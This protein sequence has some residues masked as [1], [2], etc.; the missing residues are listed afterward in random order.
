MSRDEDLVVATEAGPV[1]G[2]VRDLEDGHRSI[3]FLGVPYAAAPVGELR[4]AAPQPVSPWTGV[5]AAVE[6]GATPLR[7]QVDATLIPE[8]AVPGEETLNVNVFTPDITGFAPVMVWI[9]GGGFVSGSPNSPWYDGRAF[10]RDGVVTVSVSYRLGCEGYGVLDAEPGAGP[11][12]S[13]LGV[14]DQLA[15]L[16]WVRRNIAAFGGDPRRVTIAGQSA[17]ATAVLTLL[18]MPEA[19]PLFARA[20]AISPTLVDAPLESARERTRAVA[21]S[22][23][24][25]ATVEGLRGVAPDRL[26]AAQDAIEQKA[27]GL[28]VLRGALAGR[29]WGPTVDGEVVERA[30]LESLRAGVGASKPLLIGAARDEVGTLADQLPEWTNRIPA[31]WLMRSVVQDAAARRGYLRENRRLLAEGGSVLLA[32][33]VTDA[34]FRRVVPAVADARIGDE[35][36][37]T[38]VYGFGWRSPRSGWAHHCLDVPFWFDCLDDTA[39][40]ALAGQRPRQDLADA[41][42]AAAVSFIRGE[43]PAWPQWSEEARETRVFGANEIIDDQEGYYDGAMPLVAGLQTDR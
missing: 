25:P 8:P 33:F 27:K 17:G 43:E 6:P 10:N 19:Q 35:D 21:E 42:H 4:F 15:A 9:H 24:V 32:K 16:Q 37:G 12:V 18:A 28:K 2:L 1:R 7:R 40:I 11:E 22:A 23:G 34:V 26:L 29:M 14:L 3:A 5:R 30:T 38:W 31:S 20:L 36:G 41:M 13:N 39:V